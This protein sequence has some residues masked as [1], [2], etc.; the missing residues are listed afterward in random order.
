MTSRFLRRKLIT[1]V[2]S[3]FLPLAHSV[4][5]LCRRVHSPAKPRARTR[6][7]PYAPTTWNLGAESTASVPKFPDV[8]Q[9]PAV[10]RARARA[11]SRGVDDSRE[12][13]SALR[14][15][16]VHEDPGGCPVTQAYYDA[17]VASDALRLDAWYSYYFALALRSGPPGSAPAGEVTPLR[18]SLAFRS[19][20]SGGF[21]AYSGPTGLSWVMAPLI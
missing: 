2:I 3:A 7:V 11:I 1:A 18:S 14:C 10:L 16:V 21:G 4:L 5:G 12:W 8:D 9:W 6:C 20:L 13:L 17:L 19:G 15:R